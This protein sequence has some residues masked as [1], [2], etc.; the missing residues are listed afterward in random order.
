MFFDLDK[1]VLKDPREMIESAMEWDAISDMY[2]QRDE[3]RRRTGFVKDLH[4]ERGFT[5][6]PD[7]GR[8]RDAPGFNPP[9]R[10]SKP[11]YEDIPIELKGIMI[12]KVGSLIERT[13]TRSISTSHALLTESLHELVDA[14]IDDAL[15]DAP[16]MDPVEPSRFIA[17]DVE[18]ETRSQMNGLM[19]RIFN[20]IFERVGTPL[21]ATVMGTYVAIGCSKPRAVMFIQLSW[22]VSTDPLGQ[23]ILGLTAGYVRRISDASPKDLWP[24]YPLIRRVM[25]RMPALIEWMPYVSMKPADIS[26]RKYLSS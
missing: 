26:Y 17:T 12:G 21:I 3:H 25:L 19:A 22:C 8:Y 14:V 24:Y 15:K 16:D 1:P 9:R 18:N 2:A 13:P 4:E 20:R 7:T 10:V 5:L 23:K 6:N 11:S